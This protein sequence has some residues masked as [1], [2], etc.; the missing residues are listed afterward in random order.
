M[1]K[2]EDIQQKAELIIGEN[3]FV[4]LLKEEVMVAMRM[5]II[6]TTLNFPP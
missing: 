2:Y 6:F 5:D 1:E 3:D 4:E